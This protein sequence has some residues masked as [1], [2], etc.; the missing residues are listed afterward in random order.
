M[1]AKR[2]YT[3]IEVCVTDLS[4]RGKIFARYKI[5]KS[6]QCCF[7]VTKSLTLIILNNA[8][9]TCLCGWCERRLNNAIY[10]A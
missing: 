9:V 1:K 8:T 6:C 3:E 5:P 10:N 4:K 7:K 2:S